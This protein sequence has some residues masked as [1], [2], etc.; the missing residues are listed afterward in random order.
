M[1]LLSLLSHC[2]TGSRPDT[3]QKIL[4]PLSEAL[5][6]FLSWR[7]YFDYIFTY[8]SEAIFALL[9][10]CHYM[11][12]QLV[13]RVLILLAA[14]LLVV[15]IVI[16]PFSPHSTIKY[17]SVPAPQ[18][19]KDLLDELGINCKDLLERKEDAIEKAKKWTFDVKKIDKK[20][21]MAKDSDAPCHNNDKSLIVFD[22]S[23]DE[24]YGRNAKIANKAREL[25]S[26][27]N[28][29][30][31]PDEAFWATITSNAKSFPVP[32][33]TDGHEWIKYRAAYR[34]NYTDYVAR[35][36][37]AD[38]SEA[39]MNYYLARYQLWQK[40]WC[41]GKMWR[42]SCLF[43]LD[44]MADVIIQPHLIAHKFHLT[45]QPAAFLCIIKEI[46]A[47]EARPSNLNLS[48]YAE[49][50]QVELSAGLSYDQLSHRI[51]MINKHWIGD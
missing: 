22:D 16:F 30:Q 12:L 14:D 10:N 31:V 8:Y 15:I 50:P 29:T 5:S 3:S 37:Q 39:S 51:W 38:P 2:S 45:F 44:D 17:K 46:R 24:S 28:G 47:R 26:F 43:G 4:F 7:W 21:R 49:I 1:F 19:Y 25:L 33:A 35:Y 32:G 18:R 34:K 42:H 40:K 27:L 13:K 48:L 23:V 36:E 9:E 11:F 6:S 20:I 41:K